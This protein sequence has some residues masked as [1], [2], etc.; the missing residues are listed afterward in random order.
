LSREL[1]SRDLIFQS[2]AAPQRDST[3]GSAAPAVYVVNR[4]TLAREVAT[5]I[6]L[7]HK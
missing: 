7:V 2:D 6:E 1:K 4:D 3:G 5:T